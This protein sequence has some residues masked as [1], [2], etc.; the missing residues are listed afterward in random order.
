MLSIISGTPWWVWIIFAYILYLGFASTKPRIVWLPKLFIIPIILMSIKVNTLFTAGNH[1]LTYYALSALL[2]FVIG[3][4]HTMRQNFEILKAQ[5]S[6]RLEGSWLTLVLLL[7]FFCV[8]YIFGFMSY[9]M[10]QLAEEY[11]TIELAICGL[12]SWYFLGRAIA[13]SVA[14]IKMTNN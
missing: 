3:Y 14:Y 9:E 2:G 7:A 1:I 6:V 10:P 11:K 4:L 13:Y 8:K 12:F 5:M